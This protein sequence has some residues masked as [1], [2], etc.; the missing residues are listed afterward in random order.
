MK[1][2]TQNI[3]ELL[4]E[5][6]VFGKN[7]HYTEAK[8]R[9]NKVIELD[10]KNSK[11]RFNLGLLQY[12]AGK[13]QE[14]FEIL[15]SAIEINSLDVTYWTTFLNLLAANDRNVELEIALQWAKTAGASDP[16]INDAI[17][18]IIKL[19][20][21]GDNPSNTIL[22]KILFSSD[23]EHNETKMQNCLILLYKYPKSAILKK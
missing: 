23:I 14:S 3:F 16:K 8:N 4:K 12:A 18:P 19:V 7:G 20:K 21:S 1:H 11:A 10:S 2:N 15:K 22:K 6:V 13:I 17:K 5:G 9:F